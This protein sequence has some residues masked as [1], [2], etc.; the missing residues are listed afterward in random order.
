MMTDFRLKN[1]KP[2]IIYAIVFLLLVAVEVIIALYVRDSFIRP[3]GG[4][5]IVIGVLY[6]FVR[7]IFPERFKLLPLWLFLFAVCVEFGQAIDYVTLLG[8]G[9]IE[10]FR[11]LMG[12]SFSWYDIL[13]YGAGS[14]ICFG[15]ELLKRKR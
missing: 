10:F 4:D 13:C 7:M 11:V 8:L 5:I 2:R 3:F 14:L 1:I 9:D 12:T 6:C 15:F